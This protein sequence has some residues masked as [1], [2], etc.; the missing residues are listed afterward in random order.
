MKK[1]E[2]KQIIREEVGRVLSENKTWDNLN[3]DDFEGKLENWQS[4]IVLSYD[5]IA[6]ND[7]Y[8]V[9]DWIRTDQKTLDSKYPNIKHKINPGSKRGEL[10]YIELRS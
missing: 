8:Q 4:I 5:H 10:P 1:S 9:L 3:Q 2:L 6:Q 7:L